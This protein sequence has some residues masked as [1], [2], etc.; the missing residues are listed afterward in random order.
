[1]ENLRYKMKLK[2]IKEPTKIYVYNNKE[3]VGESNYHKYL[4]GII[5]TYI[6]SHI[7]NKG[8]GKLIIDELKKMNV[9]IY[10]MDTKR[11]AVGFYK[12]MNFEIIS[13]EYPIQMKFTT[14]TLHKIFGIFRLSLHP[15]PFHSFSESCHN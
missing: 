11:D 6:K 9:N 5:I 10:V 12:K 14:K 3:I 1:M 15:L 4:D 7:K 8:I 13:D 2:I